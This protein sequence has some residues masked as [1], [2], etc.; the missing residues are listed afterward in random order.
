MAEAANI[1][2]AT[3]DTGEKPY[4]FEDALAGLYTKKPCAKIMLIGDSG[5]GKTHSLVTALAAGYNVRLLAGENN[6]AQVF[7]KALTEYMKLVKAGKRPPIKEGQ[8][9]ICIP[10]SP[11]KSIDALLLQEKGALE[12]SLDQLMKGS[13]PKRKDYTRF[14]SILQQAAGFTDIISG[15]DMGKIT[16]W[17]NDTLLSIDS[18]TLICYAIKQHY[19]GGKLA[20]SQPEWGV[21]QGR[22]MEF[23]YMLT[24]N[25]QCNFVMQAHPARETDPVMGT[26]K[27]YPISLGQALNNSIPAAFTESVW[28]YKD[29]KN[30]YLWSTKDRLCVTRHTYLPFEE[31]IPQDYAKL[32]LPKSAPNPDEFLIATRA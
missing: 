21:M 32:N 26:V 22:L 5:T 8:V 23:L 29:A 10:E 2:V 1:P 31:D 25:L 9:G 18:L 7:F 12:K 28:S 17:G 27:I 30:N 6:S 4:N 14:V 11:K 13:D 20:I 3:P 24:E 19:I 15:K 16:D